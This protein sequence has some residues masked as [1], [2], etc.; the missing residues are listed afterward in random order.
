MERREK[1]ALAFLLAASLLCLALVGL[2]AGDPPAE[3]AEALFRAG[4]EEFDRAAAELL[5]GNGPAELP[6]G[7]TEVTLYPAGEGR[8]QTVEF[9]CGGRALRDY[10]LKNH[11]IQEAGAALSVK[12]ADVPLGI[13]RLKGEL[14]GA[15][16]ALRERSRLLTEMYAKE[17]LAG[18]P[19]KNGGRT[20]V[21]CQPD[22]DAKEAKMLLNLLVQVPGTAAVILYPV[23]GEKEG[24][25]GRLCYLLGRAPDSTAD[26]KYLCDALNGLY[27]GKGGGRGDF[28]QGSG[29]LE[30]S[31]QETA[32]ALYKLI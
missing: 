28:A 10:R 25:P 14:A 21:T 27:N 5:A 32:A 18:T 24:Q 15:G 19:E 12:E 17:L 6:R 4:R 16:A 22:L 2:A 29:K 8:V 26:C 11:V 31:W 13:R 23:P 1:R 7:V 30:P 9:L 3:R 20:I